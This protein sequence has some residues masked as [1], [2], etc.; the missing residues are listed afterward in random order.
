MSELQENFLRL[1][2]KAIENGLKIPQPTPEYKFLEGRRFRFDYAWER[3]RIAVE[4]QGGIFRGGRHVQIQG[5]LSDYEKLNE[6]QINGWL[7]LQVTSEDIRTGKAVDYV[8]RAF[9]A[10]KRANEGKRRAAKAVSRKR[11]QAKKVIS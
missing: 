10:R 4:V 2:D 11:A 1:L 3:E 8:E 9:A 7:V 5:I 6:A